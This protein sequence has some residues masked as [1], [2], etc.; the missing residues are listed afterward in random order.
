MALQQIDVR[1]GIVGSHSAKLFVIDELRDNRIGRANVAF[2]AFAAQLNGA[3]RRSG[4]VEEQQFTAEH[5][6]VVQQ[7][8]NG[9]QGLQ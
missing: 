2:L 7:D 5:S 8:L 4:S 9:F 3:K 1:I 6:F